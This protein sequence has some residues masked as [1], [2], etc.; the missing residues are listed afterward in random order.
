MNKTFFFSF[1][2]L[3]LAPSL[4]AGT[5]DKTAHA[6]KTNLPWILKLAADPAVQT[7]VKAQNAKNLS[8]DQAKSIQADWVKIGISE[9]VKPFLNK[10]SVAAMKKAMSQN[11]I[12][13]KCFVLDNQGYIVSTTPKSKDFIHGTE[14]KF[15]KSFNGG[16]GKTWVGPAMLDVSTKIYSVQVAVPVSEGDKTLGILIATLSLE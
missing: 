12:L 2:I 4:F 5:A 16:S 13:I 11:P 7:D 10:P 1:L 8:A 6:A 9:T 14:E 3:G 15:V